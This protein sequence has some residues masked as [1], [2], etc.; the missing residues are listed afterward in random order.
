MKTD[1]VSDTGRYLDPALVSTLQGLDLKAKMIV[2]GFL[3]GL[4]K[5]PYHG[6]SI[7]FSQHRPY[8]LG[9][10]LKN[11]DWKVYGKTER[12]YVK[13]YEEE[14]NLRSYI[15]LDSSKSMGFKYLGS[16]TKF[17]YGSY[18]AAALAYLMTDQKDAVG[19]TLFD[20]AVRLQM[21]PKASQ[22]YLREILKALH[23]AQPQNTTA[24]DVALYSVAE[25]IQRRGLVII[26][27]DFLDKPASLVNALKHFRFKKSEV[28][29]FH[30]S[31][32]AELNLGFE[33]DSMFVDLETNE[34]MSV[35]PHQLRKDYKNAVNEHLDYLK[36]QCSDY[37]IEF[38]MLSTATP[39]D[40][41]LITY[42]QKRMR[43][44]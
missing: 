14:T 29:C 8:Q 18:L 41:T 22:N 7:E 25:E 37:G 17:E 10:D 6:F 1:N 32:P 28:L 4:H 24:T 30:I 33:H 2:E 26:I 16:I 43:L 11:V 42:L 3:L 15:V 36:K 38:T 13:Q 21:P 12:F 31:D 20:S 34:E 9:D 19:L 35:L 44:S 39:F 23:A 27:S 40:T 5:S